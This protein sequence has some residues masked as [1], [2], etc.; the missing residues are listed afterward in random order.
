MKKKN[1]FKKK[2]SKNLLF[3]FL[4]KNHLRIKMKSKFIFIII[5]I[6]LFAPLQIRSR[7]N[8]SFTYEETQTENT[9]RPIVYDIQNYYDDTIVVRLTRINSS[10]I[11][12]EGVDCLDKYLSIRTIYPNGTAI[13]VDIPLNIQDFNFCL[14]LDGDPLK[15]Y[16]LGN[17]FLLVTYTIAADLNDVLTYNEWGMVIDLG[18]KIY[19]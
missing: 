14:L 10:A 9:N 15:I 1:K 18:G 2:N 4:K 16:A 11:A 12:P 6:I 19:R 5:S 13:P 17:K 7:K 3:F 8:S